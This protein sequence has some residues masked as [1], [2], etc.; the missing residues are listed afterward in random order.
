MFETI[1]RIVIMVLPVLFAVGVHEAAHGFAAWKM[2]DD[3]AARA[4][5]IT[6]NP[7]R[8]IDIAGSIIL[9]LML[10][11]ASAPFVFGYARP[12]PINPGLF[13]EYKKGV[14]VVSLAGI[15]ANL[16]CLAASG[17]LFRLVLAGA[18]AWAPAGSPAAMVASQLLLLLWFSV[19]INAVLAVFNMI[20][21]P[22]LD[23]SRVI[24]VFL[25]VGLQKRVASMERFG[26]MIL[27][28]LFIIKADVVFSVINA[29]ITPLVVLALGRNGV[30]LMA[31]GF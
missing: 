15:C 17:I 23:G 13:R 6:L 20:P 30:A 28:F 21:L 14:I 12:V 16:V 31:T 26:I 8:H 1:N 18:R 25:P 11:L 9:P 4:G 22:P 3:T 7:L 2:G 24:T 19:L 29:L 27:L 10:V 5:R